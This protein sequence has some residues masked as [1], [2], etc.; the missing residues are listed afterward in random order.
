M[1]STLASSKRFVVSEHDHA[2]MLQN[3]GSI[4]YLIEFQ[5]ND[6]SRISEFAAQYVAAGLPAQGPTIEYGLLRIINMISDG[7]VA[8]VIILAGVLLVLIALLC[9]RFV[10]LATLEEDMQEIGIM[11]AIGISH[12]DIRKLYVVKYIVFAGLGSA[13]GYLLSL[14]LSHLF[15]QNITLYMGAPKETVG[16]II[17]PLIAVCFVF[18]LIMTYCN[19]L[20]NSTQKVTAI[21]AMYPE[22]IITR[23]KKRLYIPLHKFKRVNYNTKIAFQDILTRLKTFIALLMLYM[24]CVVLILMPVHLLNTLQSPK[25]IEYMGVS[26]SDIR[27]DVQHKENTSNDLLDIFHK[28]D[29]DGRVDKWA[30]FST[31]KFKLMSEDGN[32]LSIDVENGD[33]SLFPIEYLQG[34]GAIENGEIAISYMWAQELNYSIGNTLKLRLP[35]DT[36]IEMMITGIYQDITNG[37]KTAKAVFPNLDFAP[38]RSMVNID[39]INTEDISTNANRL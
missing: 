38:I 37:G 4:E 15:T 35:D 19:K 22:N 2:D 3:I 29:N 18:L 25:F 12:Q 24:I 28:L 23:K 31:Y 13:L 1:N 39:A 36:V 27:I 26:E 21:E 34:R 20:V 7:I 33:F 17:F 8:A 11:K 30:S 5:L 32:F 16:T 6:L 14:F 10:I 9:L